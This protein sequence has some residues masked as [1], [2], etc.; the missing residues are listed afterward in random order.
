VEE[1]DRE[2]GVDEVAWE[3]KEQGREA[4]VSVPPAVTGPFTRGELPVTRCYVPSVEK[5]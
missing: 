2:E 1:Q 5:I 4:I 3:A